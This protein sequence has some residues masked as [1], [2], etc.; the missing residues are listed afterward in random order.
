MKSKTA[1]AAIVAAVFA[2]AATPALATPP[3]DA[4]ALL[5]AAQV[6]SIVGVTVGNGQHVTATYVKTC[7]WTPTAGASKGLSAVTVSYQS[8]ASFSGAKQMSQAMTAN[9]KPG[10]NMATTSATGIGDDAFYTTMNGR[11]TAL[12][13]KKGNVSFKVAIYGEVPA[14]KAKAM[15]KAIALQALSK[16]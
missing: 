1:L 2:F 14:D 8:A 6:T 5:T 9:S 11:Y 4:C 10:S 12:L 16:V 3:D 7:T 13:V 15:E